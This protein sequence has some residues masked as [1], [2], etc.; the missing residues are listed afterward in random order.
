MI[1][2]LLAMVLTTACND[3]RPAPTS[4]P[5]LIHRDGGGQIISAEAD[6]ARLM[7]WGGQVEI[8]DYCAS[9]CVIFTTMPNAC[10]GPNSKIGFHGSNVNVGPIG[11]PQMAKYMRGEVKRMFLTVWQFIPQTEI[12]WVKARDYV[13]LD[14]L[15]QICE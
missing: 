11:N 6:R 9:A 3:R 15:V 2:T 7:A 12:H 8:R 4:E 1:C 5:Y 13:K 10:I 14:P